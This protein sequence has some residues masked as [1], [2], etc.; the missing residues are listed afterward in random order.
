[1]DPF[2]GEVRMFAGTFAPI[3]WEPCDGRLL[4][5][6]ENDALYSLLG[7]TY[8][9][10]GINTFGVPDLRGRSPVHMGQGL[11]LTNRVL[12]QMTGT[13][14][15]QLSPSQIPAH[16]HP[17]RVVS[18][19]GKVSDPT[20]A[21]WAA[22]SAGEKQYTLNAPNTSMS[23][24][25]TTTAGGGQPHE[26]MAPFLAVTFIIATSGIYPSQG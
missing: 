18:T 26:N 17:V 5:I 25:C 3:G 7:T 11:G 16:F 9:G 19:A 20:N 2:L 8:G 1:M 21:E 10:D 6:A 4:A 15:V 24:A 22:S 13:E 12:G 23:A 14:T